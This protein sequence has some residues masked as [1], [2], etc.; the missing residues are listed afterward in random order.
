MLAPPRG[1]IA[2]GQNQKQTVT[3]QSVVSVFAAVIPAPI[4]IG[5]NS[6]RATEGRRSERSE[7]AHPVFSSPSGF[8]VAFH[9]PGM[10]ILLPKLSNFASPPAEPGVYLR[11]NYLLLAR[12]LERGALEPPFWK[13][14][15]TLLASSNTSFS[16]IFFS[17]ASLLQSSYSGEKFTTLPSHRANLNRILPYFV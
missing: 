8:R 17:N 13:P 6:S 14:N 12:R 15:A 3:A 10:T 11:D 16:G 2:I 4:S 9:L 7:Q 1:L 5:V